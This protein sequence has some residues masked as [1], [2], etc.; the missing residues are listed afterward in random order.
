M[1]GWLVVNGFLHS[2]KFEE[3]YSCLKASADAAGVELLVRRSDALA[4]EVG[5]ECFGADGEGKPDFVLFW[6]KDICLARRLEAAGIRLFNTADAVE[7]CDNK[8]LTALRLCGK[9]AIPRTVI[10]PKTFPAVGY[11]DKTFV[12][13]AGES[14]GYPMIIKEAYGSFGAQVY[15][16]HDFAEAERIVDSVEGREFV[17]QEFVRES[18]GK[19]VRINVVGGQVVCAMLRKNEH[20]YRSNVTNGGKTYPWTPTP[21][22]SAAAI[23]ACE[24]IGLDFAGVDVLFGRDGEPV[25][26]EVNS[27]PHFKS[28]LDCTGV[29][30]GGFIMDYVA[31]C[32]KC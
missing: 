30:V 1:K 14:L 31:K 15:L 16:A 11:T 13:R 26:C 2:G 24:A 17:M 18:A 21:E 9:V 28:S 20:D 22:Q 29:D 12:K 7:I 19:D 32:L 8:A 4:G 6:D 5:E 27:N 23:A 3:I 10:A 25:V